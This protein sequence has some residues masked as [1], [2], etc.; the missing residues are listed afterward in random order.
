MVTRRATARRTR[1]DSPSFE[2][3]ADST[4][5]GLVD[6]CDR[7]RVRPAPVRN[8]IE[9]ALA[10]STCCST[11]RARGSPPVP[12]E[13]LSFEQWRQVVD[14]NLTGA[15]LCTQEAFRLMKNQTPRGG[16]IINN[17]S[18][19]AHTPAPAPRRIPPPSTRSP[20]SPRRPH[21]TAASS[22]L[23]AARSISATPKRQ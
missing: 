6:R 17:G 15:F 7:P 10:G 18:I 5:T 16:R 8:G 9:E 2:P 20:G 14:V 19:S 11:M 22:I 21:S 1:R 23:P 13:D 4:R 3:A 12:L